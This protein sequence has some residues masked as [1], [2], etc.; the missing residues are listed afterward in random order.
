MLR[1]GPALVLGLAGLG[2]L[3]PPLAWIYIG[4]VLV[5][6]LW[7]LRKLAALG[8]AAVAAEE[9]PYWFSAEEA[10]FVGRYRFYFTYPALARDAASVLAAIGLS[11]LVLS[12]WLVYRAALIQAALIGVNL[13]AVARFTTELA[14]LLALRVAAAKGDREALL[15]LELHEPLWAKIRAANEAGGKASG[16]AL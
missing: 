10:Q 12:P 9:G 8:R 3:N 6:E 14:P 13:L 5:F 4:V 2:A 1:L 7:L 11:A 15:R 16:R